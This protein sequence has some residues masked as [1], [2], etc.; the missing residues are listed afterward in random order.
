M[1]WRAAKLVRRWA[2]HLAGHLVEQWDQESA[3]HWAELSGE[4][5]AGSLVGL[6][7]Y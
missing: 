1:S 6:L 2:G 5:A 4:K 3:E 7:V